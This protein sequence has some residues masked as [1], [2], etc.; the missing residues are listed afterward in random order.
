MPARR[1]AAPSAYNGSD[2]LEHPAE[3]PGGSLVFELAVTR[4]LHA[5]AT[6][7][8]QTDIPR[9]TSYETRE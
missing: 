9:W 7:R 8:S 3:K 1:E 6:R 4:V 5:S 2:P